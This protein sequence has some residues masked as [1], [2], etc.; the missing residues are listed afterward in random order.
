VFART[1]PEARGSRRQFHTRGTELI[2]PVDGITAKEL[3]AA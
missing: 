1:A 2:I 3:T